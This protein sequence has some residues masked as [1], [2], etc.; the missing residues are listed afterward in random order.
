MKTELNNIETNSF[1]SVNAT[2]E[3]KHNVSITINKEGTFKLTALALYAILAGSHLF[4]SEDTSRPNEKYVSQS[5]TLLLIKLGIY[6]IDKDMNGQEINLQRFEVELMKEYLLARMKHCEAERDNEEVEVQ[7]LF[8]ADTYIAMKHILMDMT[9][10]LSASYIEL[11]EV[12]KIYKS[13]S[14]SHTN[15]E[16]QQEAH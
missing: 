13:H 16:F 2:T 3:E 12:E 5:T 6:S 11:D 1:T 4:I 7:K 10:W 8:N 9:M 15:R 14:H